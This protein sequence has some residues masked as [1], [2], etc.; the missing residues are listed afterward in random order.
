MRKY[1]VVPQENLSEFGTRAEA[2]EFI[3]DPAFDAEKYVLVFGEEIP[4]SVERAPRVVFAE[5]GPRAPKKAT[6]A[7]SGVDA[8]RF[9]LLTRGS[10]MKISEIAAATDLSVPVVRAALAKLRVTKTGSRR[11]MRYALAVQA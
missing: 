6:G 5:K 4:F 11:G 10:P 8:V 9:A 7:L 2:V 1:F 3:E